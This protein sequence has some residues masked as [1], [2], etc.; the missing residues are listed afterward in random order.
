M[1]IT[2]RPAGPLSPA[3][4]A[5]LRGGLVVLLAF[6]LVYCSERTSPTAVEVPGTEAPLI[7]L[8]TADLEVVVE[9]PPAEDLA[10][11]TDAGGLPDGI[12]MTGK[13][14]G[15][16]MDS[17]DGLQTFYYGQSD[18]PAARLGAL[19]CAGCHAGDLKAE[20]RTGS[21]SF[22]FRASVAS[23][24]DG[25]WELQ[26]RLSPNP[27]ED[28]RSRNPGAAGVASTFTQ[29]LPAGT[30]ERVLQDSPPPPRR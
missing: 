1:I 8:A 27:H 18:E 10:P 19:S 26:W 11:L 17:L 12:K 7:D 3:L 30:I 22:S 15:E 9:F 20:G 6:G 14:Y 13:A 25:G 16:L 23:T 24:D 4:R 2:N 28:S 5:A 29:W 21:F